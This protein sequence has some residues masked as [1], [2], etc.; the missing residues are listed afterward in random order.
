LPRLDA[1]NPNRGLLV[2]GTFGQNPF[3]MSCYVVNIKYNYCCDEFSFSV[4][5]SSSELLTP[6]RRP[7]H[8]TLNSVSLRRTRGTTSARTAPPTPFHYRVRTHSDTVAHGV[9]THTSPTRHSRHTTHSPS[10]RQP[11]VRRSRCIRSQTPDRADLVA[12]RKMLIKELWVLFKKKKMCHR[13]EVSF[14][15]MVDMR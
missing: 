5:S 2:E 14:F 6:R 15:L 12:G 3:V 4:V 1:K 8:T 10:A 7:I 9:R 11:S 13:D